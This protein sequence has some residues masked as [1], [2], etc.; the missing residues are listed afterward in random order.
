VKLASQ[1]R[2][3]RLLPVVVVAASALL[4]LKTIGLVTNGGYVLTQPAFAAGGSEAP[5]GPQ[6]LTTG[7]TIADTAPLAADGSPTAGGAV[8]AHG[9][10]SA[11]GTD[12]AATSAAAP[13]EPASVPGTDLTQFDLASQS[14]VLATTGTPPAAGTECPSIEPTATAGGGDGHSESAAEPA[15]AAVPRLVGIDCTAQGDALPRAVDPT[16]AQ[17]PLATPGAPTEQAL[18]ARLA[19]RRSQLDA[20]AEELDLRA[21]LVEAA[22]QR[23]EERMTTMQSIEQQIATLV[24]QRQ[25]AESELVAGVV[26]MYENMRPRDAAAIFNQLDMSVLVPIAKAMPPRKMAPIMAQMDP[27]R[28]QELTVR[29]AAATEAPQP[30]V[31]Q[32]GLEALPQIVGQ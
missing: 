17:V 3:V 6:T 16:G 26:T 7:P 15:A 12:E 20:Y 2:R 28:A 9:S 10:D 13:P 21:A 25:A 24:E 30:V 22:E 1:V 11:H 32:T 5:A 18:L 14:A 19:E 27:A 23:I 8:S 31:A 29:L 4:A